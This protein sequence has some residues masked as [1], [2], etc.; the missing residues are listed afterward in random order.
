MQ[1]SLDD[2]IKFRQWLDSRLDPTETVDPDD[3]R[4]VALNEGTPHDPV[5]MI[6]NAI[7]DSPEKG[8]LNFISGFTGSGKS[9]EL[10]RLKSELDAQGYFVAIA[11]ASD[12]FL[13]TEPVTIEILL[14]KLAGAYSDQLEQI[15]GL[16]PTH[17]SYWERLIHWLR[18]TEV[19]LEGF[20]LNAG[21][22]A[23]DASAKAELSAKFKLLLKENPSFINKL[24]A[25]MASRPDV[26]RREVHTFFQ[27][28]TRLLRQKYDARFRPVFIFDSFEKLHDLPQTE[29]KVSEGISSILSNHQAD[30]RIPEHHIVMTMPPWIKLM[31][32]GPANVRLIYGVKLWKNNPRRTPHPDGLRLMREVVKAR[33]TEAGLQRFFGSPLKDGRRPLVDDLIRASGGHLRDLI[34]LL[35]ETLRRVPRHRPDP[36]Q[37]FATRAHIDATIANHHNSLD[38]LSDLEIGYLI[39]I[40]STRACRY[41]DNG[42]QTRHAMNNLLNNRFAFIFPNKRDWCDVHPLLRDLATPAV[43]VPPPPHLD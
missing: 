28:A 15:E 6:S 30:L 27:D 14:I 20:D 10:R 12:Y 19:N 9:S 40:A 11:D 3:D 31:A 16:A 34:N 21:I 32:Q 41:P 24:Q 23:G 1:D 37:P 2:D 43:V 5:G 22:S 4:F 26:L 39:R 29:G 18:T 33:F 17:Q 36:T 8:S 25:H 42:P 38:G 7:G 13:P 35:R